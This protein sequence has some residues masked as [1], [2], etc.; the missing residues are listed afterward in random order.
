METKDLEAGLI[1]YDLGYA[2]GTNIGITAVFRSE[3]EA[4][5]YWRKQ[6]KADSSATM[7]NLRTRQQHTMEPWTGF[8]K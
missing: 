3:K 7:F 2:V 5:E 6:Y 8:D 1:E 4:R